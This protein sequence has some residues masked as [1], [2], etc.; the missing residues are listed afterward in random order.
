MDREGMLFICKLQNTAEAGFMPILKL[1]PIVSAYYRKR[2]VGYN[3]MYAA[4]GANKEISLLV[5]CFNTEVPDYN[6]QLYVIFPKE[7]FSDSE[8]FRVSAIQ[9]IVEDGA[10]D[11]TLSKMEEFFN[12]SY[13]EIGGASNVSN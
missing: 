13:D 4:M 2:T 8:Q 6:E 7:S 10:I 11:L 9:E 3:R 1:V 5:R 12:V